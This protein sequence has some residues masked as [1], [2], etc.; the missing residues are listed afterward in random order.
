[1]YSYSEGN[2]TVTTDPSSVDR[3]R[4]FDYLHNEAYWSKGIP[5]G[6]FETSL[7][8]SRTYSVLLDNEMV[9]F[10][11][12]VTD[13]STFMYLAD[14]YIEEVHRGK[15]Y[16]KVLMKA[17]MEDPKLSNVR[18]WLLL[19]RDAQGLYE[20]FNWKYFDDPQRVM[21]YRSRPDGIQFYS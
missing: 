13:Y 2:I 3:E 11:R 19:T 14:V 1:M 21:R 4:L 16:S 18:T 17:I 12:A 6:I 5:R 20:Q 8:Y 9:G 15:G 10:A 7:Q